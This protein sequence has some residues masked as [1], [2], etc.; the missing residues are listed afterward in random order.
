M[1]VPDLHTNSLYRDSPP[2]ES[3]PDEENI[4]IRDEEPFGYHPKKGCYPDLDNHLFA[5]RIRAVQKRASVRRVDRQ[6]VIVPCSRFEQDVQRLRA[7][8]NRFRVVVLPVVVVLGV[9]VLLPHGMDLPV[10]QCSSVRFGHTVWSMLDA[11]PMAAQERRSKQFGSCIRFGYLDGLHT[12]GLT[13]GA[14]EYARLLTAEFSGPGAT[15]TSAQS[16]SF[17]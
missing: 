3:A 13:G 7:P 4:F 14:R 9:T 16:G 2:A 11:S 5:M 6:A 12:V 1:V 15:T 8:S 10:S 17:A